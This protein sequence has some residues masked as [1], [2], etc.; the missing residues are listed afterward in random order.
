MTI[1]SNNRSTS[2]MEKMMMNPRTELKTMVSDKLKQRREESLSKSRERSFDL[3][4]KD[5][6]PVSGAATKRTGY[7]ARVENP[8]DHTF[9]SRIG[10]TNREAMEVIQKLN[11]EKSSARGGPYNNQNS[12]S[13]IET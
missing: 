4:A 3:Y 11:E 9:L 2:R 6:L 5:S 12:Q 13:Y 8:R 7:H 1:G 10:E